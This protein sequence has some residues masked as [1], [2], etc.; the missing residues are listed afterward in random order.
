M[1]QAN[2]VPGDMVHWSQVRTTHPH[3]LVSGDGQLTR[4]HWSQGWTTHPHDCV[5][6]VVQKVLHQVVRDSF[7]HGLQLLACSTAQTLSVT[8]TLR[9]HGTDTK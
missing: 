5:E 7:E 2:T 1:K 3:A 8:Q 9:K 6:T 4:M